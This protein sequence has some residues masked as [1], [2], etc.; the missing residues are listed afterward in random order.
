MDLLF[1]GHIFVHYRYL[2]IHIWYMV[3]LIRYLVILIRCMVIFIRNV[4]VHGLPH[5]LLYHQVQ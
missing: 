3:I 5:D 1:V 2:I 4:H